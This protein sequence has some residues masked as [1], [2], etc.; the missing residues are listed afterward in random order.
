MTDGKTTNFI[1]T[2]DCMAAHECHVT[3]DIARQ[4]MKDH[5]NSNYVAMDN[6]KLRNDTQ[7]FLTNDKFQ[8]PFEDRFQNWMKPHWDHYAKKY[9]INK[10]ISDVMDPHYKI[11]L[12]QTGGGYH[13]PHFEQ[14]RGRSGMAERFAVWMIYLNDDFEGGSTYFPHQDVEIKPKAGMLAIWPAAYTHQHYAVNNLIGNKWAATG[15]F[16]YKVDG[17]T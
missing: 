12:A 1:E 5:G 7:A 13:S 17:I 9:H 8:R 16:R 6:N 2:Y 14:S 10:P 15:W 3:I 4:F 11:Q